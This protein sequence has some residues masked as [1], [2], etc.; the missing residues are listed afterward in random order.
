MFDLHNR[1]ALVT[2]GSR[3]IGRSV[4]L[5]LCRDCALVA[6]TYEKN[7]QAAEDVVNETAERGVRA[8]PFQAD[9][10]DHQSMTAVFAEIQRTH[11]AVD[12]LVNNAGINI[13]GPLV[14]LG[15]DDWQQMLRVNLT[16]A[17]IACQLAALEMMRK[18]RGSIINMTSIT[19]QRGQPAQ[20]G[21]STTKAGLIGMTKSLAWELAEHGIRVN[22]IAPGWIDT[23]MAAAMPEKKKKKALRLVMSKR[24]GKPEEVAAAVRYLA[25]DE[26]NY[27]IGQTLT[28]DG[29]IQ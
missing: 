22:A 27:I 29:G 5:D 1:I 23:G 8:L 28:L 13:S 9:I 26:S 7:T 24:F 16:G 25:A 11:G 2:G 18:G 14:T 20:T 15:L 6:F 17:F 21:Y 12:L 10:A 4:V 19:G 3:G